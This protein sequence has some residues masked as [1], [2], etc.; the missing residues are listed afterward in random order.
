MNARAN[1]F[2]ALF[3]LILV[4]AV[5]APVLLEAAPRGRDVDVDSNS[6]FRELTT[7]AQREGQVP[8]IIQ[9][10]VEDDAIAAAAKSD[11]RPGLNRRADARQR[12]QRNIARVQDV[13]SDKLGVVAGGLKRFRHVPFAAM[14]A[15]E[16]LLEELAAMPEVLDIQE[17]SVNFADLSSSVPVIG[18]NIARNLGWN[19]LGQAVAILDTGV[20]TD[21]PMLVNN[22]IAEAAGC[23]SATSA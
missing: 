13:V 18:A 1:R 9:L 5:T 6:R 17:D 11:D 19:G 21:H 14:A 20:D 7:R 16:Q 10:A 4:A 8:V 23:F 12:R 22:V 2:S 15:D 3:S